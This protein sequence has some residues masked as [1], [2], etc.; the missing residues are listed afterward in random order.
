[1]SLSPLPKIKKNPVLGMELDH[2][3]ACIKQSRLDI[4]RQDRRL[5]NF[6]TFEISCHPASISLIIGDSGTK[7]QH[8]LKLDGEYSPL[9]WLSNIQKDP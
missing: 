1:M 4:E 2:A 8:S 3:K 5:L 6:R 9:K 7:E